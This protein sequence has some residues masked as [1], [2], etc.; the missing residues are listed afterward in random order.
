MWRKF[1]YRNGWAEESNDPNKRCAVMT[2]EG[3]KTEVCEELLSSYICL[4]RGILALFIRKF[5]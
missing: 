2:K 1:H 3:W 5:F 4:G